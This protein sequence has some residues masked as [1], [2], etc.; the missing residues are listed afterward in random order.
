MVSDIARRPEFTSQGTQIEQ[1]RAAHDVMVA[2]EAAKKWR[3]DL[4]EVRKD[5]LVVCQ[6][7]R[8]ARTAFWSLPRGQKKLIGSSVQLMR[9]IAAKRSA[10]DT[11]R[12]CSDGELASM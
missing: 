1:T 6:T 12:V 10:S 8:V 5:M 11:A 7:E 2:M 3:R 4:G 9:T